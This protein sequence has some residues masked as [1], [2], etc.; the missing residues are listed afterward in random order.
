LAC[1]VPTYYKS[2]VQHI[3]E[4][5]G[6]TARFGKCFL[7]ICCGQFRGISYRQAWMGGSPSKLAGFFQTCWSFSS[8]SN[9][10]NFMVAK[11]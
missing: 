5:G 10:F 3:M 4:L 2:K 11:K 7:L 8:C 1:E 9:F 6:C